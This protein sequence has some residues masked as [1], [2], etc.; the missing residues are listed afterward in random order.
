MQNKLLT[1]APVL[2]L[3]G[4]KVISFSKVKGDSAYFSKEMMYT[5]DLIRFAKVER[6][7]FKVEHSK[8]IPE[9]DCLVLVLPADTID[10]LNTLIKTKEEF[11]VFIEPWC[12]SL[13]V[14]GENNILHGFSLGAM[15]IQNI[16]L[17]DVI[18]ITLVGGFENLDGIDKVIGQ[19]IQ[20]KKLEA[21]SWL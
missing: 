21:S 20:Y 2:D 1:L 14:N 10:E 12:L 13:L 7:G 19:S 9:L 3:S 11:G 18:K 4:G 15:Y 5:F 17:S 8:L 6:V 16:V